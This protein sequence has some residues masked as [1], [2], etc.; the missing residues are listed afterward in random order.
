[1]S[2]LSEKY[3]GKVQSHSCSNVYTSDLDSSDFL[4]VNG[5]EREQESVGYVKSSEGTSGISQACPR[6]WSRVFIHV[7]QNK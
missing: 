4:A 2:Q 7:Q 5:K 6:E 3:Y 1:M